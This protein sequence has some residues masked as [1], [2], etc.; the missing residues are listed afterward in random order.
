[1][2]P[3]NEKRKNDQAGGLDQSP[4]LARWAR[5]ESELDDI[6]DH[7]NREKRSVQQ[8]ISKWAG[9]VA[10]S[11]SIAVGGVT[12]HDRLFLDP[13]QRLAQDLAQLDDIISRIGRVNMDVAYRTSSMETGSAGV[14]FSQI[15]NGIKL[16][17]MLSAVDIIE[18]HPEHVPIFAFM[19]IIPELFQAQY[20]DR[21]ISL[22]KIARKRVRK[23]EINAAVF[24]EFTRQVATAY[25]AK[26]SDSDR[27][28]ARRL[29]L[30]SIEEAKTLGNISRPWIISN[31]IRDWSQMEARHGNCDESMEIFGKLV[32]DI[33][34]SIGRAVQC[35]TAAHIV[36]AIGQL[37][38]CDMAKYANTFAK[39]KCNI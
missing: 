30:E 6:Q 12:I 4:V 7:I 16:P 24:S 31:A 17:L 1:M 13:R 36:G 3:D 35:V 32:T 22:G 33:D 15:G 18:K 39:M 10:L 9:I 27:D 5:I 34:E 2:S 23:E 29:Y 28:N 26:G 20:H 37:R 14:N 19:T 8:R 21:A 25:M 11:I 38:I